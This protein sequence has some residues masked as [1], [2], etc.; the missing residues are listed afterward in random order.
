MSEDEEFSF[1]SIKTYLIC[2]SHL[3]RFRRSR[4]RCFCNCLRDL[5]FINKFVSSA[6][7]DKCDIPCIGVG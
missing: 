6:N 1:T 5:F 7:R 4:F 2:F 3:L